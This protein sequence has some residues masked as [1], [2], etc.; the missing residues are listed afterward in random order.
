M[1]GKLIMDFDTGIPELSFEK[2]LRTMRRTS[3][4]FRTNSVHSYVNPM[5]SS[6]E[7]VFFNYS[8]IPT[9]DIPIVSLSM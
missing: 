1:R 3:N 9:D 8:F 2:I 5:N 4:V 6:K 7:M